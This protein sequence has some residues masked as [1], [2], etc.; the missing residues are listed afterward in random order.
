MTEFNGTR[1]VEVDNEQGGTPEYVAWLKEE[2][3]GLHTHADLVESDRDALLAVVK[4]GIAYKDT[5]AKFGREPEGMYHV[6]DELLLDDWTE[7]IAALPDG[8]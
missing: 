7:T 1:Y 6:G 3:E 5:L 2:V 8:I 4:A